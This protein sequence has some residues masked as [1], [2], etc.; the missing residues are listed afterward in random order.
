MRKETIEFDAGPSYDPDGEIIGYY[1]DFGDG[2][3]AEGPQVTHDYDEDG[4]YTVTLTVV[5]DSGAESS[6][7]KVVVVE[8]CQSDPPGTC[9]LTG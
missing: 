4:E 8:T 2:A 3:T 9:P 5:D 1:W 6:V 7:S